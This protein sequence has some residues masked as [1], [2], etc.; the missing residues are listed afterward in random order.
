MNFRR[1]P[2]F[3]IITACKKLR[4]PLFLIC[5]LPTVTLAHEP[6]RYDVVGKTN[7]APYFTQDK[8]HPGIIVEIIE[9]V[10][11]EANIPLTPIRTSKHATPEALGKGEVDIDVISP[12]WFKNNQIPDKFIISAR[13]IPIA[14]YIVFRPENAHNWPDRKSLHDKHIGV[15]RDYRYHDEKDYI[16]DEYKSEKELLLALKNKKTDV[17][18]VGE[19]PLYYWRNKLGLTIE[20][21]P[22]H[23]RGYLHI[24]IEKDNIEYLKLINKAIV[25][26]R[27]S[28]EIYRIF[29]A[30]HSTSMTP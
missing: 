3:S 19:L 5:V 6:L 26:M 13:I 15:V 16:H 21:G 17:G 24:R 12:S 29:E 20:K 22:L 7:W 2:I 8:E 27:Q 4:K 14:E 9:K 28:G 30:Y 18:I 25:V 10:L 1:I 23:S 11:S